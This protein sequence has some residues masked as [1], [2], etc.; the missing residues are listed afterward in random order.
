MG[1]LTLN[2]LLSFAQFEREV[3]G[4]RIRDKIAASKRRGIWMGGVVPLG[5]RVE[6]RKLIVDDAEAA[7][8]RLIYER[9]LVLGSL[10][11][12]QRDLRDRGV[13]SRIRTLSSGKVVGGIALTNGPLVQILRNRTYLGEINHRTQSHPG[14]HQPIVT[15]ELF[16]AV[17]AKLTEN[18]VTRRNAYSQSDALLIGRVY[19]DRGNRMTPT[20][21]VKNGMRYRYYVSCVLAQGRSEEAGSLPRVAAAEIEAIVVGALRANAAC[22]DRG[23]REL[24]QE[25]LDRITIGGT[26]IDIGLTDADQ[27]PIR[28]AWSPQSFRRKRELIQPTGAQPDGPL[29]PMKAEDRARH[30]QRDAASLTI[31]PSALRWDGD[32]LV[33]TIDEVA[34][35][36]P[37]RIRG[38][39]RLTPL[40]VTPESFAL[41]LPAVTAGG[42]SRRARGSR[43]R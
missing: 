15:L 24:I 13:T 5:Y 41:D 27:E 32:T 28:I 3:T 20:Y 35:P 9:Y 21:A 17:Q 37:S 8:V 30:L 38:T 11:A 25:H 12:L 34:A 4:E 18:R 40:A 26:H 31:G 42:R 39:V 10:P 19:D 14:E 22:T 1:R 23:E 29:R 16:D 2:V 43:W 6:S 36:L 7:T 33:A